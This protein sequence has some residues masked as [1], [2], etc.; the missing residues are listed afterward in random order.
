MLLNHKLALFAPKVESANL[1]D[2]L[3][4]TIFEKVSDVLKL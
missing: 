3:S 4:N 2:W 1:N